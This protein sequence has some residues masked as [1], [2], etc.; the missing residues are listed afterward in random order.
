MNNTRRRKSASAT[1]GENLRAARMAANMTQDDLS[2]ALG[3]QRNTTV[4][5]WESRSTV[6][7]PKTIREIATA[8]GCAPAILL[9]GVTTPYDDLRGATRV[10]SPITAAERTLLQLWRGFRPSTRKRFLAL[11]E[12]MQARGSARADQRSR[13]GRRTRTPGRET[14]DARPAPRPPTRKVR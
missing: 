1:F 11:F 7:L 8:L 9:R 4:S 13:A 12:D 10:E 5:A 2:T 14:A 6:P 3:F